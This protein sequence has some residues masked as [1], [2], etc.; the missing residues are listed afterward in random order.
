MD[1]PSEAPHKVAAKAGKGGLDSLKKLPPWAWIAIAGGVLVLVM[2]LRAHQSATAATPASTESAGTDSTGGYD[3]SGAYGVN[4]DS[5]GDYDT[6]YQA[7]LQQGGLSGGG[8][9]ANPVGT[10]DPGETVGGILGGLFP[11]GVNAGAAA[12]GP[13]TI[14]FPTGG[15]APTRKKNAHQPNPPKS[16]TKS[17]QLAKPGTPTKQKPS[18]VKQPPKNKKKPAPNSNSGKK[19]T[20]KK[21]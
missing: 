15:G 1:A 20:M 14:Q 21:K 10:L 11:N 3:T 13:V 17:N 12:A 4:G 6:G 18:T 2:F 19:T 5:S 8:S 7:G 16:P 9:L